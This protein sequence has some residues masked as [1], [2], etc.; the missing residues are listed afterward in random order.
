VITP[1][2]LTQPSS[3]PWRDTVVAATARTASGSA[4]SAGAAWTPCARSSSRSAWASL[5]TPTTVAPFATSRS[6]V[7]RPIPLDAPVTTTTLPRIRTTLRLPGLPP[8]TPRMPGE[9]VAAE[10]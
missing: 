5:A 2:A 10:V 7:A 8:S 9:T 6:A 4:T 3:L 1:A